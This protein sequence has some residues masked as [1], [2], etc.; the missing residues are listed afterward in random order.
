MKKFHDIMQIVLLVY[1]VAYLIFFITFDTLG[2]LFGMDEV[3]SQSMVTIFLVGLGI[4]LVAWLTGKGAFSSL[5][6]KITKMDN[7]MNRLKA[8]IYDF[9]HPQTP[10]SSKPSAPKQTPP[11]TPESDGGNLPP[12]QNFTD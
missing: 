5:N 1:F 3:T 12:R 7:E 2:N 10:A 4:F 6:S 11:K 8:K 9:E